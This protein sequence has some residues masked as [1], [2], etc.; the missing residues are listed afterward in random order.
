MQLHLVFRMG[1]SVL[2]PWLHP[3]NLCQSSGEVQSLRGG[4][5]ILGWACGVWG[6]DGE[7]PEPKAYCRWLLWR[8]LLEQVESTRRETR[9][10]PQC[11]PAHFRGHQCL[12]SEWAVK[13]RV[14]FWACIC[15]GGHSQS[16][17]MAG[18]SSWTCCWYWDQSTEW[19]MAMQQCTCPPSSPRLGSSGLDST[20]SIC[21]CSVWNS[22]F[23][24]LFPWCFVFRLLTL[25]VVKNKG[26]KSSRQNQHVL[27]MSSNPMWELCTPYSSPYS[28]NGHRLSVE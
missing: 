8:N 28:K 26:P 27:F 6:S 3:K 23:T 9:T 17:V 10:H 4:P 20:F 18:S 11:L 16:S 24:S 14:A 15:L 1:F 19:D 7:V 13:A 2:T 21:L 12:L 25:D 5:W 22:V